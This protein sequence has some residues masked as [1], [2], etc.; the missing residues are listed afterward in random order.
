MPWSEILSGVRQG[1]ILGSHLFHILC[2]LF[3]LYLA[4]YIANF[5]DVNTLHCSGKHI[6]EV[7]FRS[8]K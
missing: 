7:D 5:A 3:Y 2:G 1:S 6:K 8:W 4:F